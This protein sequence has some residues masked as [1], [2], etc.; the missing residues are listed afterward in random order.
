MPTLDA[1]QQAVVD[2]DAAR[3][4]V[5]AGPG[6]G[7]TTTIAARVARLITDGI[8]GPDEVAVITYTRSMALDL[9]KRVHASVPSVLPCRPCDGVGTVDGMTCS[10]CM[11]TGATGVDELRVGTLHAIAAQLVRA[12]LAPEMA[13][14]PGALAI[15]A[16]GWLRPGCTSPKFATKDDVDDL[17]AIAQGNVGKKTTMKALMGGLSLMGADLAKRPPESELR[18]QLRVRDLITYDDVLTLLTLMLRARLAGGCPLGDTIPCLVVDERQDLTDAHWDVIEAW[19]AKSLTVVGDTAQAIFSFLGARD[20]DLGDFKVLT[21]GGNYRSARL[22]VE[23]NNGVRERMA[24]DGACAPL[25]QDAMRD[26]ALDAGT[27]WRRSVDWQAPEV[28]R[29]VQAWLDALYEPKDVAVLA[30]TWA[31]LGEIRD[32]LEAAGVPCDYPEAQADKLW[33]TVMGRGFVGAVRAAAAGHVDEL[34]ASLIVRCFGT[35]QK[36]ADI[37]ARAVAGGLAVSAVAAG[38]ASS[39]NEAA[40]WRGLCSASFDTVLS[41]FEL[42]AP[43]PAR[44]VTAARAWAAG[45]EATCDAFLADLVGP[46]VSEA[47]TK[48]DGVAIRTIHGAK[49]LEWPVVVVASACEGG[50][51]TQWQ[52]TPEAEAEGARMLYVALT[53]AAD[54]LV[55][56]SPGNLGRDRTRE[57]AEPRRPTRWL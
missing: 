11:G 42:A 25:K 46:G 27:V 48:P 21:L 12:E 14:T 10:A 20:R 55:V 32:A 43:L 7:K 24:A 37:V 34:D 30:P 52:R 16:T 50:L 57:R 13:A 17:R 49:G 56:V 2:C 41:L 5:D 26:P 40:F 53:R 51:P 44:V 18:R 47:V 45:G 38:V 6:S 36:A 54:G 39:E 29:L 28:V 33:S 31:D 3:L 4:M 8:F 22:I 9:G 15:E 1:Y 19:G 23:H 35:G